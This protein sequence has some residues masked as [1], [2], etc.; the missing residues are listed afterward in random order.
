MR[1]YPTVIFY[2]DLG[3]EG[4]KR[5]QVSYFDAVDKLLKYLD[6]LPGKPPDLVTD[7][8]KAP[9]WGPKLYCYVTPDGRRVR[10]EVRA[11]T[12][13]L[14]ISRFYKEL[15]MDANLHTASLSDR[16][17]AQ[18][19]AIY[20]DPQQTQRANELRDVIDEVRELEEN[21]H[22]EHIEELETLMVGAGGDA[23]DDMA[24][25]LKGYIEK[26]DALAQGL[27]EIID[28]L[29][30]AAKTQIG[31]DADADAKVKVAVE[32]VG[33]VEGL[34]YEAARMVAAMPVD[35][36]PAEDA[37]LTAK[38]ETATDYLQELVAL[39]EQVI[40]I[41][42]ELPDGV[43]PADVADAATAVRA[44]AT[45]L[46]RQ[47]TSPEAHLRDRLIVQMVG[48]K[49]Q[50]KTAT[51]DGQIAKLQAE[52]EQVKAERDKAMAD[53]TSLQKAR[54]RAVQHMQRNGDLLKEQVGAIIDLVAGKGGSDMLPTVLVSDAYAAKKA[55]EKAEAAK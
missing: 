19:R 27:D 23:D 48:D 52:L 54:E 12:E 2:V 13:Y 15:Q 55:R 41:C 50:A 3:I 25:W 11:V 22:D 35:K 14:T 1:L 16:L 26:H 21:Q 31:K 30:V 46:K 43:L 38:V 53:F 29:P 34:E 5:P 18:Y 10:V 45:Y 49:P 28:N 9:D 17:E 51:D 40:D 20:R 6:D 24:E 47:A 37:S 44:I 7:V 32:Y 8:P 36:R 42:V 33:R 39:E 4:Q